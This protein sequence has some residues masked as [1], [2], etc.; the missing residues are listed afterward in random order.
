MPLLAFRP[1]KARLVIEHGKE[2][3]LV[4]K[5]VTA[6]DERLALASGGSLSAI[7]GILRIRQQKPYRDR[8]EGKATGALVFVADNC[9]SKYQID[10]ALAAQKFDA[11]LQVALA[12]RMPTKIFVEAG[13]R[14]GPFRGRGITYESRGGKRIKV[15]HNRTHKVLPVSGFSVVLPIDVTPGESESPFMVSEEPDTAAAPATSAQI[16]ELADEL[17]VFQAETHYTLKAM[18]TVI[19]VILLLAVV[20]NVVLLYR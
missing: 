18:I 7:S 14:H 6:A 12:G 9:G 4:M 19:G 20:F 11:V 5:V 10:V 15:W 2:S 13:E 17:L 16:A 1:T 8:I 3:V